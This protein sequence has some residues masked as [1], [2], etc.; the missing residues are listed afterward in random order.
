MQAPTVL[1]EDDSVVVIDKPPGL[2][3]HPG[4]GETGETVVDWFVKKYPEV[5]QR[6]W[7]DKE[8]IG[9]VHRLDKDTSGVMVLAKTPEI[10]QKLQDQFKQRL[11]RKTYYALVYG[12]PKEDHGTIT[13]W[14]GRHPQRRMEQAVLPVQIGEAARREAVSDYVVEKTFDVQKQPISFVRFDPKTGRMHQL[15]VHAKYL[16]TPILGDPV[17]TIKPAKRLSKTLGLTRQLLHAKRLT[18]THPTTNQLSS[19]ESPFPEDMAALLV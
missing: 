9:I 16:G 17:Y 15:R 12:Q 11:V 3:V 7:P 8:R 13:T 14:L 10:L 2:V 6:D 18:F 1:Y 19:Y 5:T 4:A